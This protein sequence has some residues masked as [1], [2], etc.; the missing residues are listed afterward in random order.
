MK[1]K[2]LSKSK[3]HSE[4]IHLTQSSQPTKRV[5]E[6]IAFRYKCYSELLQKRS[7]LHEEIKES[8]VSKAQLFSFNDWWR[9]TTSKYS[10]DPI[11]A[12]GSYKNPTGGRFNIGQIDTMNTGKVVMFPALY[13]AETKEVALKE[14]YPTTQEPQISSMDLMLSS[15]KAD[16]F[17]KIKG[18]VRIF[19]IDKPN[20][21]TSFVKVLKKVTLDPKTKKEVAK[22]DPSFRTIQTVKDLKKALYLTYWKEFSSI[23]DDPSPSQIFG[24]IVKSCGI[25]GLLYSSVHALTKHS[26]KCLALFLENFEDSDSFIEVVDA[27]INKKRIDGDTFKEFF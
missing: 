3:I 8:L 5:E 26:D 12:S 11:N 16:A 21:L 10:T 20:N 18:Q 23:Y 19:D 1:K 22:L 7:I 4:V 17:F 27:N 9:L 25:E 6:K 13:L 15:K 14:V 24:Q 2:D